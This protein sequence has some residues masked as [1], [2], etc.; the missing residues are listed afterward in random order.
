VVEGIFDEAVLTEIIVKILSKNIT[1]IPRICRDKGQLIAVFPEYLESFRHANQGSNV[2]KA[3]VIRD[4][5]GKD[6]EK[7]KERMESK[8]LNRK[9]PFEVKFIIIVQELEAWLLADEE[10]ISKVTQSRSGKVVSRVNVPLESII[11][12]K[13]MLYKILTADVPY[14]PAVAREIA[15]ESDLNRIAYRCRSF[16]E[17]RQ[18]VID[19]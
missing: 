10:A 19:C 18:A 8:I 9:Y 14:T 2:D 7:L 6:P 16:R 15:K 1:L 12:P 11:D 3:I 17:F 5:D 13:E 4:A